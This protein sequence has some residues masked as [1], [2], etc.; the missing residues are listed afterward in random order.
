VT[1]VNEYLHSLTKGEQPLSPKTIRGYESVLKS[2]AKFLGVSIDDLHLHL[3]P[4]NLKNYATS[5]KGY[6]PAGTKLNLTI[7]RRIYHI[8]EAKVDDPRL[9]EATMERRKK[10]TTHTHTDIPL[11]LATLQDSMVVNLRLIATTDDL[12]VDIKK[13]SSNMKPLKKSNSMCYL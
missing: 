9:E 7:L 10:V 3:S 6:K 1:S 4:E 5:R 11:T 2:F 13:T 12:P 8:N